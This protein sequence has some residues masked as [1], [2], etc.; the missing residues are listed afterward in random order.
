M[1]MLGCL[2]LT[3]QSILCDLFLILKRP[4]TVVGVY[5]SCSRLQ[6]SDRLLNWLRNR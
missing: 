5:A 2:K 1:R 4:E 3:M 6:T